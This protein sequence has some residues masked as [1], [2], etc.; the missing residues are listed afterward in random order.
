MKKK[1]VIV[2]IILTAAITM[3]AQAPSLAALAVQQVDDGQ[4][5]PASALASDPS[6]T[7]LEQIATVPRRVG[8]FDIRGLKLGMSPREVGRIGDRQKFRRRWNSLLLTSGS[9]EVEAARAANLQLNRPV[10]EISKPQL[11]AVEAFDPAGNQL[12]LE[13]T[14]EPSGPKLSDIT[15]T[16]K[17]N[18]MTKDQTVA[19]LTTKYGPPSANGLTIQWNNKRSFSDNT[20]PTLN[21]VIDGNSMTLFLRQSVAYGLAAKKRMDERAQQIAATNGGGVKF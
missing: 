19:A 2:G 16:A 10:E 17:L 7:A 20:S 13:F 15:Y 11:K 6:D 1:H 12:K 3:S 18:G 14:L 8:S 9:F 5:V 4:M 21:V